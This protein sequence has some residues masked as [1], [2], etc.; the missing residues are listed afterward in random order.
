M[1]V[2]FRELCKLQMAEIDRQRAVIAQRD[3]EIDGLIAW[4]A[5]DADAHSTLM[6]IY[7]DPRQN[8]ANKTRA[9]GLALPFEKAKPAAVVVQIDFRERVRNARL[10]T[11]AETKAR[12]AAE[13]AAKLIEHQPTGTVLGEGQGHEGAWHPLDHDDPAA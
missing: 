8:T 1:A 10:K 11:M 2:D 7:A 9:A 13:D 12:W 6:A 4:I 3:A 5:S